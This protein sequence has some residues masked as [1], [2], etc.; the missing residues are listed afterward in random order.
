MSRSFKHSPCVA[1]VCY[2]SNK[3]DKILTNRLFRR[4]SKYNL[5]NNKPMPLRLREIRDVWDFVS[6]GLAYWSNNLSV[7]SLR[8]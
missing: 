5:R 4:V 6:D 8:K 1:V 7:K 2:S 3:K